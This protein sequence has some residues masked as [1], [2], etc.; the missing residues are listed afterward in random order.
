MAV[1]SITFRSRLG[2]CTSLRRRK[3]FLR[4][5]PDLTCAAAELLQLTRSHTQGHPTPALH[6]QQYE[7]E[8]APTSRNPCYV[9]VT[10]DVLVRMRVKILSLSRASSA[11]MRPIHEQ[12]WL[13]DLTRTCGESQWSNIARSFEPALSGAPAQTIS[14]SCFVLITGTRTSAGRSLKVWAI[15]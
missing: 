15:H 10:Q 2:A 1:R 4:A 11:C 8:S 14:H 5:Y 12:A 3:G 9:N 7:S 13:A 6:D